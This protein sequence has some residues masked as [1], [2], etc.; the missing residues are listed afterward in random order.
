VSGLLGIWNLDGRPVQPEDLGRMNAL[1]KHRGP[2]GDAMWVRGPVGLAAQL[3]RVTPQAVAEVQP[4][5]SSSGSVLLFDGR[6]D[7][8]E[9]LIA[10]LRTVPAGAPD[11]ELILA[12][13]E[14]FGERFPERLQGDFA[15]ALF[16][17]ARGELRLVR[18][19]IG[20]K[21]LYYARVAGDCFVFA[22][23]I[24]AILA[25]R[26]MVARPNDAFLADFVF[27]RSH[28]YLDDGTTCFSGIFSVPPGHIATLTPGGLVLRRYWDFDLTP[29]DA[30][31][32]REE[33][34]A[35][36]RA[37]L[38]QAVRRRLRSA[39][40]VAVSVSGGLDSSTILCFANSLASDDPS[41]AP[42]LGMSYLGSAG[43]PNDESAFLDEV[44]RHCGVAMRRFPD[45][46]TGLVDGAG[47]AVWEVESPLLDAQGRGTSDYLRQAADLGAR[48]VLTGHWGD[49]FLFDQSYLVDLVRRGEWFLAW[50]HVREFGRWFTDAPAGQFRRRFGRDLMMEYLPSSLVRPLRWIRGA[51]APRPRHVGWYS[52]EFRRLPVASMPLPHDTASAHSW[53]LYV[54]VRSR[55]HVACMEWNDKIAAAAGV[56]MAFPFLDRDLL[57]FLIAT[58]GEMQSPEG[59]PK[60][61][62][63][64]AGH[65]MV[66]EAVT[67]RRWK[68]DF[69]TLVN[70]GMINDYRELVR[71]FQSDC[72]I[73]DRGYVSRVALEKELA[74]AREALRGSSCEASW[75]L[76]DLL[77]LELWLRQFFGHQTADRSVTSHA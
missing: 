44:E 21:P 5:V 51:V 24:K 27:R 60:A 76:R 6:L 13:Y 17:E 8:R 48:V 46:S 2:D 75:A 35:E 71:M 19:A 61:L 66:P 20:V 43:S 77:G 42:V 52:K 72:M 1:L 12:A 58:P 41:L 18:D 11:T 39:H 47:K 15:A 57:S 37:L 53:S 63:R 45:A 32:P 3:F 34:V 31:R 56:D 62:L 73:V 23:E 22:S 69:T 55:Y 29:R 64:E 30:V 7:N 36:F 38:A 50:S 26:A 67:G 49:Q 16:D 4:A 74:R 68:A 40:P 70:Q 54:E 33:C 10:S 9:E 59:I 25:H 65:R 14:A 28:L